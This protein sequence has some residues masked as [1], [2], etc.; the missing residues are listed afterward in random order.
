M[1][2]GKQFLGFVLSGVCIA[3]MPLSAGALAK[4]LPDWSKDIFFIEVDGKPLDTPADSVSVSGVSIAE[5]R[6]GYASPEFY[7]FDG[8]GLQDLIVGTFGG[9]FRFYRNVGSADEPRFESFEWLTDDK[10]LIRL[11]NGC[12]MAVVPEFEDINND[13]IVDMT[14]SSYK[15]GGVYWFRGRENDFGS[16]VM[17][18]DREGIPVFVHLDELEG[19]P[20]RS[21]AT[22]H[23]WLDLDEDGRKDLVLGTSG[24][25]LVARMNSGSCNNYGA[26]CAGVAATVDQPRFGMHSRG[27]FP[28][29]TITANGEAAVSGLSMVQPVSADWDMDGKEDLILGTGD[30]SIWFLRN[31]DHESPFEFAEPVQLVP[32]SRTAMHIKEANT[33]PPLA[34]GIEASVDVADY[35]ND[36]KPDLLIGYGARSATLRSDLTKVERAEL[37]AIVDQLNALDRQIGVPPEDLGAMMWCR[38]YV[39]AYREDQEL[40]GRANEL[41]SQALPYFEPVHESNTGSSGN[42]LQMHGYVIVMLRA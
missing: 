37:A 7:D 38:T 11:W 9:G 12:C 10:G 21:L 30:G 19:G 17:L 28:Q 4:D 39:P 33:P 18:T 5:D 34:I 42:Y 14:A 25:D 20:R 2:T 31:I 15:P 1:S 24:G 16:R 40:L 23:T 8:D 26:S 6:T 35:N 3:T 32:P 41:C 29:T 22:V 13:G 27:R 36:G